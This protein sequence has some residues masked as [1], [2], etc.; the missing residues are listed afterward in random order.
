MNRTR[1]LASVSPVSLA[2]LSIVLTISGCVTIG[3]KP[4]YSLKLPSEA[5]IIDGDSVTTEIAA[6]PSLRMSVVDKQRFAHEID[7]AIRSRSHP[8]KRSSRHYE[9]V[10]H[11]TKYKRGRAFARAMMAGLGSIRI[12]GTVFV[13]RLPGKKLEG[14]FNMEKT[15]TWG[16][17][18]GSVTDIE[19]VEKE[20]ARSLAVAVCAPSPR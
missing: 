17:I 13:Y 9:L 7:A 5:R 11:L 3:G 14:A 1:K 16:G 15:F 8:G 10:V 4:E 20:F 6:G 19:D 2:L 12:E 18:Y